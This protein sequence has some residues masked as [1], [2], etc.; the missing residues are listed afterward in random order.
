MSFTARG[1]AT[2]KPAYNFHFP[3][4]NATIA[5]LL[6]RAL[7][8]GALPG[9]TAQDSVLAKVDYNALDRASSPVRIRLSSTVARVRH[10]G[11]MSSAKEVEVAYGR[12]KKVYT[13][14]AKAVS[15][16]WNMIP[17]CVGSAETQKEA[18][19]YGVKVPL[20]YTSVSLRNWTA[21]EK[22]SINSANSPGIPT[23]VCDLRRQR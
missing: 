3:D 19:K 22:L 16:R 21:F 6:V 20:V 18:L 14:R 13:V 23:R 15:L 8:P 2:P 17:Y 9:H 7:I 1:D 12:E 10:V 11:A 4:G 5:R